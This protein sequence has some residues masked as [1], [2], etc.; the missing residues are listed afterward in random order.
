MTT[1]DDPRHY[2]CACPWCLKGIKGPTEEDTCLGCGAPRPAFEWVFLPRPKKVGGWPRLADI[3]VDNKYQL[4]ERVWENLGAVYRVKDPVGEPRAL[5]VL[6]GKYRGTLM[7][8]EFQREIDNAT[9]LS[10]SS[11]FVRVLGNETLYGHNKTPCGKYMVMEWVPWPTLDACIPPGQGV[12]EVAALRIAIGLLEAVRVMHDKGLLHHDL[13]TANIFIRVDAEGRL[14]VRDNG[15]G[16]KVG[17]LGVASPRG[18]VR[19]TMIQLN[20]HGSH[21]THGY[22]SPERILPQAQRTSDVDERAD[23]WAVGA[24]A[25]EMVTGDLPFDDTVAVTN[26]V[27][28]RLARP[29]SMSPALHAVIVKALAYDPGARYA[30]A[31]EF[32]AALRAVAQPVAQPVYRS[33]AAAPPA[34]P[35]PR[36]MPPPAP[37]RVVPPTQPGPPAR[38]IPLTQPAPPPPRPAPPVVVKPRAVFP[39]GR[40]LPEGVRPTDDPRYFL[41][42]DRVD[43]ALR[44]AYIPAGTFVRGN[45]KPVQRVRLT[46]PFLVGVYPVTVAEYARFVAKGK[47]GA[48][49]AVEKPSFAQGPDHPVVNVSWR[50]ATAY[51]AATG[52]RLLTEA[53][54][55]YVARGKIDDPRNGKYPKGRRFP[56]GD[57]AP[58]DKRLWWNGGTRKPDGTGA[59]GT[60]ADGASPFGVH[61]L[62]GNV[63]EWV[64]DV[65]RSYPNQPELTDPTAT[66]TGATEATESRV[67]RGGSWDSSDPINVRAAR[68]SWNVPSNRHGVVGFRVARG[69]M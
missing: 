20:Q 62:S 48:K 40:P 13:R 24:I 25:W 18:R 43:G 30:S 64:E 35:A 17:D 41:C 37:P 65:Y 12:P 4:D 44:M 60:C 1:G 33:A 58:D 26:M 16:V 54:W 38:L 42:D 22:M 53:E 63:W 8:Q 52:F 36:P 39:D 14:D 49:H 32:L 51:C 34:P 45:E 61:D 7:E 10:V 29:A 47:D 69:V 23:L 31:A 27:S 19:P 56:W 68:R 59:V 66:P 57:E 3:V 50:D 15:E 28:S 9:G 67:L 55:E 21:G 6:A 11:L 2:P 46:Q 5:K